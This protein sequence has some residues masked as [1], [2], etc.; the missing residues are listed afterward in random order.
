MMRLILALMLM[1]M[2]PA[3]AMA[4]PSMMVDVTG[5]A[6]QSGAEDAGS[7]RRRA[8][9]DAVYAAALAG[10]AEVS[11]HTAISKSVITSDVAIVR[12]VG[13]VLGLKILSETRTGDEWRV[14][15]RAKIGVAQADGCLARQTLLV[16]AYPA[17]IRVAP[18]A[19][20]WTE[21]MA[22][23][24]V[25]DL[26][27]QLS[28]NPQ[29]RLQRVSDRAMPVSGNAAEDAFDYT[30]LT[31]GSNRLGE[32]E[33]A[34][35]PTLRIGMEPTATGSAIRMEIRLDLVGHLG[36]R[37][38]ANFARDVA[39]PSNVVFGSLTPLVTKDRLHL[40]AKLTKGL[41]AQMEDLL[42]RASCAPVV[43]RLALSGGVITVP[44]G[45][46]NGLT[47]GSIAFTADADASTQ[48]LEVVDL[49]NRSATLRPLDPTLSP[50][51]FAGRP[52][53]F[54]QTD[55]NGS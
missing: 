46:A 14:T 27:A 34:Y 9:A 26:L 37:I 44:V 2:L 52:V 13:R 53:R 5:S 6:I 4:A 32:G 43:A 50:R 29:V 42:T 15:I 48:L 3:M 39:L 21:Q 18:Q 17:E 22:Q 49:S 35:V 8:L 30:A 41:K 38:T 24:V 33:Y 1:L 7:A 28:D 20:A 36:N 19:P 11:G 16:T 23:S 54:V 12:P 25:N 10:G 55:G 40:T 47:A 45:R 31:R 51:S